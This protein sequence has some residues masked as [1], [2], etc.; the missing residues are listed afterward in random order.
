MCLRVPAIPESRIQFRD[1]SFQGSKRHA[2]II[3]LVE[4][5]KRKLPR[6][7]SFRP[8]PSRKY[9][10]PFTSYHSDDLHR[11]FLPS[12]TTIIAGLNYTAKLR[13]IGPSSAFS[14]IHHSNEYEREALP[15]V[16]LTFYHYTVTMR[17]KVSTNAVCLD[18]VDLVRS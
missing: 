12:S 13:S 5:L 14:T 17:D 18:L 10:Y 7:T 11:R 15:S 3:P 16:L 4:G 8:Q 6:S 2:R 1:T 9:P